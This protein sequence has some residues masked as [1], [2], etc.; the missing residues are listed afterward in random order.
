MTTEPLKSIE[1]IHQAK[2]AILQIKYIGNQ[3]R[4][5]STK[6]SETEKHR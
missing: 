4:K 3:D 2:K 6:N 1:A 5:K